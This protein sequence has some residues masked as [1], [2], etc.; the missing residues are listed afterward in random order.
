M[1]QNKK[2]ILQMAMVALCTA[3]TVVLSQISIPLPTGVPVTLQ[4][5]ALALC[6]YLLG[7]KIGLLSTGLY[8]AM[9][10][11]GLPVFSGFSGGLQVLFGI[12]GGFVWGF[13]LLVFLCGAG[14]QTK[15]KFSAILFGMAGIACC[16]LLGVLQF[17]VVSETAVSQSFLL[18]SLPYLLKDAISILLAYGSAVTIGY[19]LKKAGLFISPAAVK[20]EEKT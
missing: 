11:V 15:R 10:A 7:A 12:R 17:S 13:L 2:K 18:V 19:S 8:I 14:I 3:I 20:A 9:G 5:L 1:K 16:H 4:T 6:G